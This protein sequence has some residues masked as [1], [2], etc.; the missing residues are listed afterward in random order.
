M[1]Y[2]AAIFGCYDIPCVL[3]VG[4]KAACEQ[5]KEYIPEIRTAIVKEGTERNLCH[6][7]PNAEQVVRE[8]TADALK[9]YRS[10]PPYKLSLPITV[11]QTSYRSDMIDRAYATLTA[12]GQAVERVGART[13]RKTVAEVKNYFDLRFWG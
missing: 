1:S 2:L 11:E 12:N 10:I 3:A 13:I 8:A 7:L 5:A 4:D 9:N 6:E